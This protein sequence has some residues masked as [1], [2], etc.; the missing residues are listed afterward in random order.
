MSLTSEPRIIRHSRQLP[1]QRE[2]W[3]SPKRFVGYVAGVGAGKTRAAVIKA[4][5]MPRGSVGTML[6]PTYPMLRDATLWTFLELARKARILRSFNK[7]EGTAILGWFLMDEAA[8]SPLDVWLIMLG[9]LRLPPGWGGVTTTPRGKNWVYK[10]FVEGGPD[11]GYVRASSRTNVY[12]PSYF[13]PTLEDAYTPTFAAQ[14]IDGQFIDSI[15]GQLIP[16]AWIDRLPD[17]VRPKTPGGPRWLTCDLGEGGGRDSTVILVG[18]DFGIL[19]GLES[20]WVGPIEA[21]TLIFRLTGQFDVRQDRIVYD[22]GGG[23]G[24]QITPY[25]E[26]LGITDAVP[27]RGSKSGGTKFANKRTRVAWSLKSRLDPE[28]PKPPPP[29]VFDPY[30]PPPSPFDHETIVPR[31]RQPPFCLPAERPWWPMLEEELKALYWQH[32]GKTIALEIKEDMQKRLRKG[33]SPNVLDALL[34]RFAIGQEE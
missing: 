14:E 4:F 28:K 12:L 5:M 34:M 15:F 10:M 29:L 18:D 17:L 26:E 20:P 2:F 30:A 23:R 19:H 8:L 7:D 1:E 6:A 9:R 24:L 25:L 13:V 32:R 16:D 27:Y 21:A 33:R 11:Y 22:A 3:F 31:E